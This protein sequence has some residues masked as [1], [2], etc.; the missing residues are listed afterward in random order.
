L[1]LDQL[2]PPLGHHLIR[3][4]I[5]PHHLPA[6]MSADLAKWCSSI[7]TGEQCW[8]PVCGQSAASAARWL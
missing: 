3:R 6:R 2:V 1:A 4:V 8:A 5:Q 7:R